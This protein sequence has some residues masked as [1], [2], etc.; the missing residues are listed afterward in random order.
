M[1]ISFDDP[2]APRGFKEQFQAASAYLLGKL[3]QDSLD[4]IERTGKSV[5][6]YS[7]TRDE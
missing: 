7:S 2:R 1:N 5:V 4:F 6:L 3:G